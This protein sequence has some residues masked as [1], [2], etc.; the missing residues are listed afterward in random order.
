MIKGFSSNQKVDEQKYLTLQ[1]LTGG[2]VGADMLPKAVYSV[3]V[4]NFIP[5]GGSVSSIRLTAHQA[6]VGDMIRF[7]TGANKGLELTVSKVEANEIFFDYRL[8]ADVTPADEFKILKYLTLTVSEDGSL[9]TSQGPVQI[10]KDAAIVQI[11]KDTV[12]PNNTVAMPVEIVAASGTEITITA[13]DI[14]VQLSHGGANPDS[15]QVGDGTNIMGVNA[16]NE[17]L[18][19]DADV[20]AELVL[21]KALL[22]S[23]DG[24]D[25]STA[26]KQDAAKVTADAILA[27]I[28]AA[29]ATEAKQDTAITALGSLLTELELKADLTEIQPVSAAALP[30]PTGAATETTLA[31]VLAKIIAAPATEAKQDVLEAT[32]EAILAKIISAPATEAKQDDMEASLD[33]ILTKLIAA[34][35]TE[36][37][38]DV[39]EATLEAILAKIIAAPATEAKQDDVIT[40]LTSIKETAK[41][42]DVFT[43]VPPI[44]VLGTNIPASGAADGV[45]LEAS[46]STRLRKIQTIED[47]G[48]YIGLYSGLSGALVL[49]CILPIAGG[50]VEVD[51]PA[52]T[53]LT[54]KHLKN[55][56][57]D[58]DTYFAANLIG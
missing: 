31:S 21:Q 15:V 51:I 24:K 33:S 34:P 40:E 37:K 26:A 58:T 25:F 11:S 2:K 7:D 38:Q 3:Q 19:K 1:Q 48:E 32:L 4:P 16:S 29:P 54:I 6:I 42:L 57:I 14:N 23:L 47:V 55:S 56:V 44:S 27:K 45:L 13:G 35:A 8:P 17:A 10:V 20:L 36:A 22:T 39:L 52:S 5:E 41:A 18:T 50:I 30:L 43:V 46:T 28:I 49:E 12:D 53:R 9:Q